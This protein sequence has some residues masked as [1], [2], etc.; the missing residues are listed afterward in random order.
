MPPIG[1]AFSYGHYG[2]QISCETNFEDCSF[3]EDNLKDMIVTRN[4]FSFKKNQLEGPFVRLEK[5]PAQIYGLV[6]NEYGQ[7]QHPFWKELYRLGLKLVKIGFTQQETI[8]GSENRME[9][10]QKRIKRELR[11][12]SFPIFCVIIDFTTTASFREVEE[13]I[14]S[15][16]GIKLDTKF[17]KWLKLPIPTEWVL[18][19]Q[20]MISSLTKRIE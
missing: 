8:K 1:C 10:I 2:V 16:V 17:A 7:H 14:R 5:S 6:I 9:I 13:D 11:F 20:E 19:S 4:D 3:K 12:E 18:T 15:K